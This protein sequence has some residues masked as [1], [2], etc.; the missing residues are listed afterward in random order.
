MKKFSTF[1]LN[2]TNEFTPKTDPID[3]TK[4]P[5]PEQLAHVPNKSARVAKARSEA[6]SK[7]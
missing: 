7:T 5:T 4:I 3:P 2:S 6:T 1:H